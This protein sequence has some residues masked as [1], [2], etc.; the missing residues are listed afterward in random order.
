MGALTSVPSG[1]ASP[2]EASPCLPALQERPGRQ[3]VCLVHVWGSQ[4]GTLLDCHLKKRQSQECLPKSLTLPLP[5]GSCHDFLLSCNFFL[6]FCNSAKV[7]RES[8]QEGVLHVTGIQDGKKPHLQHG[9]LCSAHWGDGDNARAVTHCFHMAAS[10]EAEKEVQ[11]RAKFL[12]SQDS[13][14]MADPR[15]SREHKR[16]CTGVQGRSPRTWHSG[17]YL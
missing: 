13:G 11:N 2:A 8:H 6:L 17:S 9:S 14:K 5:V 7:D 10:V 1:L 12:S 4:K 15:E 16:F 3:A